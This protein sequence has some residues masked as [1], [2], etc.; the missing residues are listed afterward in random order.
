[1]HFLLQFKSFW[2]Y[3]VLTAFLVSSAACSYKPAYLQQSSKT[4]VSERWKV[5]KMNASRL[6]ADEKSAFETLGPPQFVRFY[7]RLSLDREKVYAWVYTEPVHFITFI[8]GKKIDYAVLDVDL[9]SLNEFQREMWFWGGITAGSIAAL[10]L[11]AYYFF[12]RD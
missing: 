11:L 5:E 10:G 9:S 7:R 12:G 2:V 6:S 8:D 4:Q 3:T 1:M